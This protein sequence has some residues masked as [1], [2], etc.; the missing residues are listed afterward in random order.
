MRRCISRRG[1]PQKRGG[2]LE[3]EGKGALREEGTLLHEPPQSRGDG[4]QSKVREAWKQ[5]PKGTGEAPG[6]QVRGGARRKGRL[7]VVGFTGRGR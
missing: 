5:R 4:E 2:R 3:R 1:P 7:M 6:A